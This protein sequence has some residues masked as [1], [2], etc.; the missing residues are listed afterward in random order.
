ME[1]KRYVYLSA[2]PYCGAN[3]I[4]KDHRVLDYDST[5]FGIT[6]YT[7][8]CIT[9]GGDLALGLG[10]RKIVTLELLRAEFPNDLFRKNSNFYTQKF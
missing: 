6:I 1:S 3:R 10:G 2:S 4:T 5:I 7:L 8:I 9:M